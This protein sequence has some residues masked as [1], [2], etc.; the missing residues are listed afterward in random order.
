MPGYDPQSRRQR[1]AEAAIDALLDAAP[2]N[3]SAPSPAD[4]TSEPE[5]L[6][7]LS[8]P[9]AQ[10]PSSPTVTPDPAPSD[11]VLVGVSVAGTVAALLA[12]AWLWRRLR[13]RR[14]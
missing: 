3:G 11:D 7:D 4:E 10:L 5:A 9:P 14:G 13:R 8:E 6:I 2:G 12:A 1:P